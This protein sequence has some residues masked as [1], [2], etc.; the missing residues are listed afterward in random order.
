M[1][2]ITSFPRTL[3]TLKWSLHRR[4]QRSRISS[5]APKLEEQDIEVMPPQTIQFQKTCINAIVLQGSLT[6]PPVR[7]S[8]EQSSKLMIDLQIA[9]PRSIVDTE[10]TN[11][12]YF[13]LR[14]YDFCALQ[15]EKYLKEGDK[16]GVEG[17][18]SGSRTIDVDV[19]NFAFIERNTWPFVAPPTESPAM[20]GKERDKEERT[21]MKSTLWESQKKVHKAYL[22]GK[23][24]EEIVKEFNFKQSTVLSY[25]AAC[26]FHGME[27]DFEYLTRNSLLGP[28][29]SELMEMNSVYT[30]IK[31]VMANQKI[32]QLTDVPVRPV[33]ELLKKEKGGNIFITQERVINSVTYAQIATVCAMM[34]CG[35]KPTDWNRYR[36][37]LTSISSFNKKNVDNT[38]PPF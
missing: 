13:N 9:V 36:T 15:A 37:A 3:S 8:N 27:V 18:M 11:F 7:R 25:L 12:S 31:A 10:K 34:K 14:C 32:E 20:N 2:P 19:R 16:I 6:R 30:A 22:E 1:L 33:H 28:T 4:S 24:I 23:S 38:T 17:R 35:L 26:A 5:S 21:I 29:D